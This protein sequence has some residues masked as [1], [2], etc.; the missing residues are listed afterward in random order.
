MTKCTYYPESKKVECRLEKHIQQ[1]KWEE[2]DPFQSLIGLD[3]Q[4][5]YFLGKD[6][7][8][9][10]DTRHQEL[11]KK[12]YQGLPE[13]WEQPYM[14]GLKDG[15]HDAILKEIE[16]NAKGRK[17]SFLGKEGDDGLILNLE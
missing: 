8:L 15:G 10:P 11:L 3:P 13:G 7:A 4:W 17:Q 9:Q 5:F 2:L 14:K 12:A 6:A 1:R 16:E